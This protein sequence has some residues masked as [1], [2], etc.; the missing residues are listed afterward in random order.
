MNG[1]VAVIIVI[2]GL[3]V[4]PTV[5]RLQRVVGPALAG[6]RVGDHN[7]LSCEPE[8]PY[9]RRMRVIDAGFNCIRP[10][11]ACGDVDV[12]VRSRKVIVDAWITFHTRDVR[13]RRQ[14]FGDLTGSFYKD[15][16]DDV[17]RAVLKP[18]FTQP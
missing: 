16:V 1:S 11:K 13:T 17:E 15:S 10:L 2:G 4:P 6:V 9:L 14:C 18:A 5:M 8:C 7:L 12:R 3:A